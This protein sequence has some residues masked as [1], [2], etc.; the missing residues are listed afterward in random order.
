[1]RPGGDQL[2]CT[3]EVVLARS[4]VGYCGALA[5]LEETFTTVVRASTLA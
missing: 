3:D 1:M 2:P 5:L 4:I